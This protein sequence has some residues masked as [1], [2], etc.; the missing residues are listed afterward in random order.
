VKV[1]NCQAV[2]VPQ[3]MLIE[4]VFVGLESAMNRRCMSVKQSFN[5]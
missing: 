4:H 3:L 1:F 5:V 2:E